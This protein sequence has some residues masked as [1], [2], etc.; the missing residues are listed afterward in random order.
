MDDRR[1]GEDQESVAFSTSGQMV[2][3]IGA[4]PEAPTPRREE[5]SRPPTAGL[6]SGFTAGRADGFDRLLHAWQAQF[7]GGVSPTGIALAW[8]DWALHLG[9]APGKQFELAESAVAATTRFLQ[10]AGQLAVPGQRDETSAPED[11]RFR[12]AAWRD[13]PFRVLAE[14]FQLAEQ[15]ARQ[16]TTGVPGVR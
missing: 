2:A 8:W 16:A 13:A 3:P 7:T 15:L 1:H 9:N 14:G 10:Q 6:K 5:M 4:D 11:H 12:A